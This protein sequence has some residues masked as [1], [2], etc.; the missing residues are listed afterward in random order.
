M[1]ISLSICTITYFDFSPGAT[2][3]SFATRHG[4]DIAL[5]L[6]AKKQ[7]EDFIPMHRFG[8]SREVANVIEFL[9]S[10]KVSTFRLISD[11]LCIPGFICD[12]ICL[13]CGWYVL[14]IFF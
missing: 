1:F 14:D 9:A 10:D 13:C 2:E 12:R 5:L 4:A 8:T 11:H 3:T 6:K 7:F